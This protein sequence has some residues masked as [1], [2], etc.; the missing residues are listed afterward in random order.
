MFLLEI[1]IM[2]CIKYA[3]SYRVEVLCWQSFGP[4]SV[5]RR[6]LRSRQTNQPPSVWTCVSSPRCPANGQVVLTPD[7][8]LL[9]NP[10]Q[11]RTANTP[12]MFRAVEQS[13]LRIFLAGHPYYFFEPALPTGKPF[14]NVTG[15]LELPSAQVLWAERKYFL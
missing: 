15:V 9:D 2:D 12:D 11:D 7:C 13:N 14:F 4:Y 5:L 6:Q 8:A 3:T 1:H 10:V